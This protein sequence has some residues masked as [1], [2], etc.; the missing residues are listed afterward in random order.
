MEGALVMPPRVVMWVDPLTGH[1]PPAP[2]TT[3]DPPGVDGR[4]TDGGGALRAASR[5]C[6]F[7]ARRSAFFTSSPGWCAT[8][9]ATAVSRVCVCACEEF[10][11]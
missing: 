10:S 9:A 2:L 6:F 4:G 7:S 5:R 1:P 11:Q 3:T 8:I